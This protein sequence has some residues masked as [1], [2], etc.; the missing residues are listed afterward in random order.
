M[1]KRHRATTFFFQKLT[2][3]HLNWPLFIT[4][5]FLLF[6]CLLC[7]CVSTITV[8]KNDKTL[9]SHRI[10]TRFDHLPMM[11]MA[12]LKRFSHFSKSWFFSFSL[13]LKRLSTAQIM[14][15][16]DKQFYRFAFSCFGSNFRLDKTATTTEKPCKSSYFVIATKIDTIRNN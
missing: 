4:L 8:I 3:N 1:L 6:F 16:K 11:M 7:V 13:P 12:K 10:D 5:D 2:E 15:N 14:A 9:N